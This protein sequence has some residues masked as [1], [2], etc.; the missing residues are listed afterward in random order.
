[1]QMRVTKQCNKN[2]PI[3]LMWGDAG[4]NA[5]SAAV[6]S[7]MGLMEHGLCPPRHKCLLAM[8]HDARYGSAELQ[9]A[10]LWG[11]DVNPQ[12]C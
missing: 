2:E 3:Y 8:V 9:D 7:Q 1:M 12:K 4:L 10:S 5:R 6:L 11:S